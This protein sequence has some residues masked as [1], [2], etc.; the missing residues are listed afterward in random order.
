MVYAS[1]WQDEA[2]AQ[3][4]FEAYRGVLKGKWKNFRIDTESRTSISGS[5]DDGAFRLW[6][7]GSRLFSAEGMKSVADLKDLT[8]AGA[9]ARPNVVAAASID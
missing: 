2:A 7:Q 4:M 5:G 8:D 9:A 3:K 6:L 1:E